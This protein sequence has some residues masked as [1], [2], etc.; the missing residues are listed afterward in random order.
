MEN[1]LLAATNL[2]AVRPFFAF[3]VAIQPLQATLVVFASIASALYHLAEYDSHG[4][5]GF[6]PSCRTPDATRG[7]L[8]FDRVC[9]GA[10]ILAIAPLCK[11]YENLV[12]TALILLHLLYVSEQADKTQTSLYVAAHGLWHIG[13]FELAYWIAT[14]RL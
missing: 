14:G 8:V 11:D 1:V 2:W 13:V 7:L 10:A 9:A 5:T 12:M 3:V 4:M 6:V